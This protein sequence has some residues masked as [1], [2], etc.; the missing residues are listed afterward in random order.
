MEQPGNKT[1]AAKTTEKM[2]IPRITLL[3]NLTKAAFIKFY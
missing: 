2:E 1:T 3:A